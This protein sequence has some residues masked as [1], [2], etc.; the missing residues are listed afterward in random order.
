MKKSLLF[1]ISGGV[2]AVVLLS[3]VIYLANLA[4]RNISVVSD[5]GLLN[6][7]EIAT[8]NFEKFK[9]IKGAQ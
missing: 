1:Y 6:P 2:M 7:P 9:Q 4:V 3:Y 8:Y 5:S